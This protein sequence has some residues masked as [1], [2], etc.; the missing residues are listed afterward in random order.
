[1]EK[2][3][4]MSISEIERVMN[5]FDCSGFQQY[6]GEDHVMLKFLE[7]LYLIEVT[8]PD[9]EGYPFV[10]KNPYYYDIISAYTVKR[11]VEKMTAANIL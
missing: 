1:M 6:T 8:Y 3:F 10:K 4:T 7:N 2:T 5:H 9:P 11:A